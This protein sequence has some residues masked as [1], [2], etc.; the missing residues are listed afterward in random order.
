MDDQEP[1]TVGCI[2]Q[3]GQYILVVELRKIL[4]NLGFRH[5]AGQR[6]KN[7]S[8]RESGAANAGLAET[9]RRID[10][11]S[12][13]VVH[14]VTL[15]RQPH[16]LHPPGRYRPLPLVAFPVEQ[17]GAEGEVAV[18]GGGGEEGF[19]FVEGHEQQ[20]GVAGFVPED[21]FAVDPGGVIAQDPEAARLLRSSGRLRSRRGW[22]GRGRAGAP[23]GPRAPWP[24]PGSLAMMKSMTT[25]PTPLVTREAL[26]AF[27]QRLVECYAPEKVILFGSLARGDARW[28]S[29]ADVLVVMPFEGR[30]LAKIHDLAALSRQLEAVV[31]RSSDPVLNSHRG[32]RE[33]F[34]PVV[35]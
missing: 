9:H 21:A 35:P 17:G 4:Q 20:V 22:C 16:P 10:G 31:L 26:L 13:V 27:T 18:A 32:W 29:D 3:A 30:H 34:G 28:D 33:S 14:G 7:V 24:V 19:A 11:D 6:A 2:S 15:N 25:T 23:A 1:F 8:H 12:L 5:A